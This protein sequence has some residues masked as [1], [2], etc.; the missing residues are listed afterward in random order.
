MK[1]Y[2]MGCF[3]F[4]VPKK[5]Q[6]SYLKMSKASA[7][8]WKKNGALNYV[9]AIAVDTNAKKSG[10]FPKCVNLKSSEVL[11]LGYAL[12]KSRKHRDQV[13]AKVMKDKAF[14]ALW[15]EIPFSVNRMVWGGFKTIS[16]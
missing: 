5:H 2:Y 9:E 1:S 7:R 6:K 4:P 15:S 3:I 11:Y 13:R 10:S 12:Y 16:D 8:I 14:I